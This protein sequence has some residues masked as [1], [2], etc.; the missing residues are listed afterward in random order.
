[1]RFKASVAV[2]Q[3]R[4]REGITSKRKSCSRRPKVCKRAFFRAL[5]GTGER[6][7]ERSVG[8][9]EEGGAEHRP[10]RPTWADHLKKENR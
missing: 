10:E 8:V 1:M 5:T 9:W 3:E 4:R 2:C 6:T 7:M